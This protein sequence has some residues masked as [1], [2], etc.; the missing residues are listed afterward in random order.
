MGEGVV[1]WKGFA[2]EAN[3]GSCGGMSPPPEV[4]R[5][6]EIAG[7]LA[8]CCLGG[9]TIPGD[10]FVGIQG[11]VVFGG[12]TPGLLPEAHQHGCSGD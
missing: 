4:V 1:D 11:E 6:P 10:H 2:F 12:R 7:G 5:T 9:G 8:R 3:C